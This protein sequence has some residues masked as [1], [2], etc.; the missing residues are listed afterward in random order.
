MRSVTSPTT[1]PWPPTAIVSCPVATPPP[2]PSLAEAPPT[3][4]R[5]PMLLRLKLAWRQLWRPARVGFRDPAYRR[6]DLHRRVLRLHL[7][8]TTGSRWDPP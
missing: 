2:V 5:V 3:R 7:L 8:L 1:A 4:R 6:R